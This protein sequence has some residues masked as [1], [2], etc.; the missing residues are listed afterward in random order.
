[1]ICRLG[2]Q[3]CDQTLSVC[4]PTLDKSL[5][6]CSKI[7]RH[8]LK[9][10][11]FTFIAPFAV[12]FFYCSESAW[13][14]RRNIRQRGHGLIVYVRYGWHVQYGRYGH[15]H[16]Y[17]LGWNVS[18]GESA[19]GSH[20]LVS[21]RGLLHV[22]A[23]FER[24]G[25]YRVLVTVS[26]LPFQFC[27]NLGF[28]VHIHGESSDLLFSSKR[29]SRAL[30][31]SHPTRPRNFASQA[32]TTTLAIFREISYPQVVHFTR[33][34]WVWL[35]PPPLGLSLVIITYWAIITLFLT[36]GSIVHDAYY[37]ERVGFR[38][39][40]VSVTQVPFIFLLAG[41]VNIGS[42]FLG[43][44]YMDLNWLHRW[45]SR[46][47]FVT[48]T[49]HGSFFLREW[50]R[51]DFVSLE[52]EMMPMVKYGFGLWAVL[53]WTIISS[54]LPLRR[55]C[56]EFF[57]LQHI[58]SAGVFLWLLHVHVPAYASYNVW[59]AVAFALSGRVYRFCILLCRNIAIR[60]KTTDLMP[61]KRLGHLAELQAL[62]GEITAV[63][64]HGVGFSWKAGQH[65]LLWCPALGPLES[66]PF[67]IANIPEGN[68]EKGFDKVQLII[69]ARSGFTRKLFRR[70][71]SSDTLTAFLTGPFG[72]LPTWN[73]FETLVL[74]SAS[75]GASF[76]LPILETVL[77]DPCCITRIECLLL[78]RHVSHIDGYV[79]RLRA[80]AAHAR[81]SEISLHITVAITGKYADAF[82]EDIPAMEIESLSSTSSFDQTAKTLL[83]SYTST[84]GRPSSHFEHTTADSKPIDSIEREERNLGTRTD[85][86]H[87]HRLDKG[88][89][90]Q[91]TLGRPCL[92]EY[93]RNPVEASA[94]ETSVVI[95][96]VKSLTSTVRNCVATLSDERAVHKGTG[97][98]GIHLHVEEFGL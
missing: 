10:K 28:F 25:S 45:V 76:T 43:S 42:F 30:S 77:N 29:S 98:Q 90:L 55:L 94:G 12:K 49:I 40:W 3:D 95:C 65:V 52:L 13:K 83:Q 60:K 97:A 53:L 22:C 5:S 9:C 31:L 8:A 96:G 41:K 88:S 24:F 92:S 20:I 67:T 78:I 46:T 26:S 85:G 93:I 87:S 80:A 19:L 71:S 6:S 32:Y 91:Y 34:G 66:H 37:W 35:S 84:T 11:V 68:H 89:S 27:C 56:Y 2:G 7:P 72:I 1:M 48:V 81:S 23:A 73:T 63:T 47:L 54:L 82:G 44:S 75:T 70:A 21:Y 62:A 74:I 69:R 38:A 64:V 36:A 16:G 4:A 50:V 79:S 18:P 59:M 61:G 57:V 17:G 39:A 14:I 33:R 58:V 15:G 86:Q 51:A